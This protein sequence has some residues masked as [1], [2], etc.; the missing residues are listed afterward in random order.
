MTQL[1]PSPEIGAVQQMMGGG[2]PEFPLDGSSSSQVVKSTASASSP[3]TDPPP[4]RRLLSV[5]RYQAFHPQALACSNTLTS[6]SND[7]EPTP[8]SFK[9][10]HH[11]SSHPSS[12]S[13]PKD[14]GPSSL[15]AVA[16]PQGVAL[17]R[18]SRPH[19]P[20]LILSHATNSTTATSSISS[21]AFQPDTPNNSIGPTSRSSLYLAA[22]RGSG[23]L[24]WDASGHNPSPLI[25]RL[26]M[27]QAHNNNGSTP[28]LDYSD[29][30]ITSIA[31]KPSQNPLLATTTS[32]S[33][34]LW[35]LRSGASF[36]PS[37][38]FGTARAKTFAGT[39]PLVQVACAS[40]SNGC[41]TMDASGIV[42]VY[43]IRMT[44]RGTRSPVSTIAAHES[45][46]VGISYIGNTSPTQ[47]DSNSSRWLTWGLD[48]P[49][50]SAV[51][52]V[53]SNE[54]KVSTTLEDPDEYWYMG[55]IEK[56]SDLTDSP[57]HSKMIASI[58]A[59]TTNNSS[60]EYH[61][62]A[63]CARPNL[64]CARVCSS[65]VENTFLAVGHCKDGSDNHNDVGV[66][67]GRG[68]W[69]EL[70]TLTNNTKKGA[71]AMQRSNSTL[72]GLER[73][74]GFQGGAATS[75]W[76][77]KALLSILGGR[78][79]L[80]RLQAAELAFSGASYRPRSILSSS[81]E[82]E[83]PQ[84]LQEEERNNGV[85]LLLCCLSD[86]GV[87]TTHVSFFRSP[88]RCFRLPTRQSFSV[89]FAILNTLSL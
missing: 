57:R 48:S 45:A 29:T 13:T 83:K 79:D 34:S 30:R 2:V 80:G 39:S 51:V 10:P 78:V 32:F 74:A 42:R 89:C 61:L 25:G 17:F 6:S 18:L 64:A 9:S 35:D 70:F 37:L 16:G 69:A 59:S 81:D 36:K 72:F 53:W 33:L 58:T 50:G 82:T 44:E 43:D 85:D 60:G 76:D 47:N 55:N 68:W 26:G 4:F 24:L 1:P 31:W 73:V 40:D 56:S 21:L 63:F 46:G 5:A 87:V 52:K 22:A 62:K 19:V 49:L 86:T 11:P 75:S 38:R 67:Q 84:Q 41:A 8:S 3:S 28:S 14:P 65:P 54:P 23:V 88:R 12:S 7:E 71:D 20:L 15:G 77:R 66:S 27:D